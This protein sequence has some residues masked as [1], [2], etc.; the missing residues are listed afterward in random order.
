MRNP[1]RV[2]RG[3][4]I[5]ILALFLLGRDAVRA[6]GQT[7]AS[8]QESL[9]RPAKIDPYEPLHLGF[10]QKAF[11]KAMVGI[12]YH[13]SV[14]AVGGWGWLALSVTGDL[15]PGLV[16]ET[17]SN[18]V[19][20][21][22]VPSVPG[23]YTLEISAQDLYGNT[24]KSDFTID[25]SAVVPGSSA[26]VSPTVTDNEGITFTDVESVFF[27]AKVID[28]ETITLTDTEK[29]LDAVVLVDR[30]TITLTDVET[31]LDSA[32]TADSENITLTDAE[33]IEVLTATNIIW[34]TPAPITYG[35]PLSGTQLD[36]S[37]PTEDGSFVYSP[38]AGTILPGGLNT[39]SVTFTPSA[40]NQY[41]PATATVQLT[42]NQASQAITFTDSLPASAP[43]SAGLSYTLSANGGGSGKPVTFSLVS[44]PATV[45]GST[46]AIIGGGNVVIA[47]NQAGNANYAAAP[48]A[49]QS[50]V[51]VL[52]FVPLS[53]PGPETRL[54]V[55]GCPE[56]PP[57]AESV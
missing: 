13:S 41:A 34:P 21:T 15:P 18:T 3:F 54:K 19:A 27:P 14:Q 6:S 26:S 42:V 44:G 31:G 40:A 53:E 30:E 32:L 24:A 51:R 22:G 25:V 20:V 46:L 35:T 11:P 52:L 12:P 36:A 28:N 33:S 45:N 1:V 43:Y 17:G 49:T 5:I 16:L 7:V 4:S 57:V 29:G 47:A 56:A 50:I 55:T 23:T 2:G 48:Q 38:P 39:L 9:P 10:A 8:G 37:V